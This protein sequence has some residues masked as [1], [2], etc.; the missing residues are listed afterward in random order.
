MDMMIMIYVY[1][2]DYVL[3]FTI[4][5]KSIVHPTPSSSGK[6]NFHVC[7]LKSSTTYEASV[8]CTLLHFVPHYP[9]Y[10]TSKA[11]DSIIFMQFLCFGTRTMPHLSPPRRL[12]PLNVPYLPQE[13]VGIP[14]I[15][16]L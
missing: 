16:A 10:S 14:L 2:S 1:T 9:Y 11:N 15:G 13:G 8:G 4:K 5:V 6:V 3:Q 7:D 12:A